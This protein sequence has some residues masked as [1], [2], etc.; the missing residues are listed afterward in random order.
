MSPGS[1]LDR[2]RGGAG[3]VSWAVPALGV[4]GMRWQDGGPGGA[5]VT[6]EQAG[7][8][9]RLREED[10]ARRGPGGDAAAAAAARQ[11]QAAQDAALAGGVG[12]EGA[13][14]LGAAVSR[15]R[16]TGTLDLPPG[17]PARGAG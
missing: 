7:L 8:A 4:L 3:G 1:W 2:V 10:L 6:D 17:A 13:W 14:Q 5:G 16:E 12:E 9:R 15:W 11:N